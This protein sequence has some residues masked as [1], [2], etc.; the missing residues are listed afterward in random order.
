MDFAGAALTH[1]HV[2]IQFAKTQAMRHICALQNQIDRLAFLQCDL[3]GLKGK[4]LR[5][6]FNVSWGILG[7]QPSVSKLVIPRMRKEEQV[8]NVVYA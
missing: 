3:R 4:S 5:R 2:Y 7:M 6:H 1:P 8:S